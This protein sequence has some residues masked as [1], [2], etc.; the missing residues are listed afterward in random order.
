MKILADNAVLE[1][2]AGVSDVRILE[3]QG[4]LPLPG[5]DAPKDWLEYGVKEGFYQTCTVERDGEAIA[6]VF[7]SKNDRGMLVVNACHSLRPDRDL[8]ACLELC[9]RRL[10]AANGC[11]S[12]EYATKRPGLIK[13]GLPLRLFDLRRP[14]A[15][16][17]DRRRIEAQAPGA[18]LAAKPRISF[19]HEIIV[20]PGDHNNGDRHQ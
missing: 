8:F 1:L 3:A 17:I 7:Y 12:V 10:A 15:P 11:R 9:F 18:I 16:A 4:A 6:V 20:I 2:I 19:F 5:D 13:K 14:H